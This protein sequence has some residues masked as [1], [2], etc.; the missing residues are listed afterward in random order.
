MFIHMDIHN[1]ANR[2][3]LL[4]TSKAESQS[5][6][7]YQEQVDSFLEFVMP[8]YRT[9]SNS[10]ESCLKIEKSCLSLDY[11]EGMSFGI[12]VLLNS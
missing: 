8:T 11:S 6:L 5:S 12:K 7:V 3:F 1:T 2:P 9:Y 4:V 10:P